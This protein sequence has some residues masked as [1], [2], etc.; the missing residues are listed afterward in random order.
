MPCDNYERVTDDDFGDQKYVTDVL[1][2]R[3]RDNQD[4]HECEIKELQDSTD[5]E[6]KKR[7]LPIP[8]E[9]WLS[10]GVT[11]DSGA[12]RWHFSDALSENR[13]ETFSTMEKIDQVLTTAFINL[14]TG[15]AQLHPT[16]GSEEENAKCEGPW[17]A[18]R[19][20]AYWNIGWDRTKPF[21]VSPSMFEDPFNA[22]CPSIAR[23]QT[24]TATKTG[25]VSQITFNL[26]GNVH[27]E[28]D[29][30]LELRTTSGGAP[31]STVL[32]RVKFDMRRLQQG[33]LVAVPFP[34]EGRPKV[35]SG[36][37][38]AW[39]LRS[40]FTSYQNHYGVGG[41]GK[42]CKA[43]PY[44]GGDAFISYDNGKTWVKHGRNEAV[45]YKEGMYAPQD[46]GFLVHTIP[47]TPVYTTQ[48]NA[49]EQIVYLEPIRAN[50]ITTIVLSPDGVIKAPTRPGTDVVFEVTSDWDSWH[51]LN[52]G[53]AYSYSFE[54]PYP[55]KVWVRVVLGND[56]S[57]GNTGNTPEVSGVG[58]HLDTTVASE[59][60]IRTMFY[61][62]PTSMP[63]GAS[64]WDELDA[65]ITEQPNT[66][67]LVDV[68]R[69]TMQE[70]MFVCDGETTV[71]EL[72]DFPANPLVEVLHIS[73]GGVYTEL[74]EIMHYTVDYETRTL[75]IEDAQSS[76]TLIVRYYP[77]WL[78]GLSP[79]ELPL[80]MDL[81]E[82]RFIADG[83]TSIFPLKAYPCD[84][85][86][87]VYYDDV[88]K[89]E[90]TDYLVDFNAPHLNTLVEL[91][92]G[93][94]I[95]VKYT[96]YLKDTALA[97]QFRLSRSNTANDA[98]IN[99]CAYQYR[100]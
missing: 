46:F 24:W 45:P 94:E 97:L 34:A 20:N 57:A 99:S 41:W 17:G 35:V 80:K 67:V 13:N 23:A 52:S 36:T 76:G 4:I 12:G 89:E 93:T 30:Y 7:F 18:Y 71:F 60:L 25:L 55:T 66:T 58:I 87:R 6:I 69:G 27:A 65:D 63:L 9:T 92:E 11:L 19:A 98:Y 53:N 2:K 79:D 62:P 61:A 73:D 84:P 44:T 95:R 5:P 3:M 56:G 68:V 59:G 28:D 91:P 8:V 39:V 85:L 16:L 29:L 31:T 81:F 49:V 21:F 74:S 83:D 86:R 82:E 32:A 72:F 37:K 88:E 1:L 100:V 50:P 14:T 54:E 96:P 43:D 38:Y 33:G 90:V 26:H 48:G 64:I 78:R 70:E 51:E 75:T 22:D 77:L 15:V 47:D 42:N 40:P 10:Y